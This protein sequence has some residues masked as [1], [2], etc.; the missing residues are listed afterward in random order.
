MYMALLYV[1]TP[2]VQDNFFRIVTCH[3]RNITTS[4]EIISFRFVISDN[5]NSTRQINYLE[6]LLSE[7]HTRYKLQYV[8]KLFCLVL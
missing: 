5:T 4:V 2:T 8:W 6:S 3:D 7:T 1:I